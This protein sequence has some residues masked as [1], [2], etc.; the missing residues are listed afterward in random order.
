MMRAYSGSAMEIATTDK[1]FVIH[2]DY[3]LQ[4]HWA[5]FN[6]TKTDWDAADELFDLFGLE[7]M[8]EDECPAEPLA[9][10]WVKVW[11]AE[12]IDAR[13]V[14]SNKAERPRSATA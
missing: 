11:C 2:A 1:Q 9:M 10:S 7:M 6:P 4:A 14:D 12:R 5:I 3:G 8:D 13:D